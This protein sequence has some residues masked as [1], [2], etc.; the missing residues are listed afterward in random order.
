MSYTPSS[1]NESSIGKLEFSSDS[2][3][4]YKQLQDNSNFIKF[5]GKKLYKQFYKIYNKV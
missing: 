5:L 2:W 1:F 4:S 3:N